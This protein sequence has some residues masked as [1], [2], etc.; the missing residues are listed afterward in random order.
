MTKT[1][2][3]VLALLACASG[4]PLIVGLTGCAGDRYN[5]SAGIRVDDPP[6]MERGTNQRTDQGMEDSRTAERV[7]EALAARADYKY[8]GVKV[9][10]SAGVVRLSGSVDTGAQRNS[11]GEVAGKVVGVRIV[12]NNLSV[13]D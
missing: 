1:W 6:A 10:A 5:Q 11:A 13:E 3:K 9:I 2:A 12:E 4:F 8:G 7:R